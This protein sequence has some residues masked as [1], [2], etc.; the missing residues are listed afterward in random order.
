LS[1]GEFVIVGSVKLL[2]DALDR[3]GDLLYVVFII[4]FPPF[5]LGG[6]LIFFCFLPDPPPIFGIAITR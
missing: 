2:S 3:G 6:L 1:F 5:C 4:G